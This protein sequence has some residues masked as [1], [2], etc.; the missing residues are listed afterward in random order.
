MYQIGLTTE[1]GRELRSVPKGVS[2]RSA[3]T[4]P[5][6]PVKPSTERLPIHASRVE[7]FFF[8]INMSNPPMAPRPPTWS[9]RISWDSLEMIARSPTPLRQQIKSPLVRHRWVVMASALKLI[10]PSYATPAIRAYP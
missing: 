3:Y 5:K 2:W 9:P 10:V 1:E 6:K 4:N 7:I 8:Q